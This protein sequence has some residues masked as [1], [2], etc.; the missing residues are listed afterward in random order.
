[1]NENVGAATVTPWQ[2]IEGVAARLTVYVRVRAVVTV[3]VAPR[4]WRA[5][6]V[7]VTFA[8]PVPARAFGVPA[9]LPPAAGRELAVTMIVFE[10]VNAARGF[11]T[12]VAE[13]PPPLV[14]L[15]LRVTEVITVEPLAAYVCKRLAAFSM[16][17]PAVNATITVRMCEA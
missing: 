9:A 1:M 12:I 15:Q 6:G 3:A 13:A 7:I 14:V 17:G 16:P 2:P 4:V 11:T 10:P 5:G 8:A